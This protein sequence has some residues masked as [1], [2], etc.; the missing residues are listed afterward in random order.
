MK[1]IGIQD[2]NINKTLSLEEITDI[3]KV[4]AYI[5]L[6]EQHESETALD[7]YNDWEYII[8]NND[9]IED[10]I[11]K[12]KEILIKERIIWKVY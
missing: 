11:E 10:L 8:E 6:S 5:P 1:I 3:A 12:V 7:N 4:H 2:Y 9:T